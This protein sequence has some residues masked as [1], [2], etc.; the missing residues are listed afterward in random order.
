MSVYSSKNEYG[1]A[2]K[3]IENCAGADQVIEIDTNSSVSLTENCELSL[4]MCV[5]TK[6]F[7][8]AMVR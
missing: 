3:T 2:L 7:E 5:Q 8:T 4:N 1:I 6:G